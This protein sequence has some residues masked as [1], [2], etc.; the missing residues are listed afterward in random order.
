MGCTPCSL[1]V[2]VPVCV[3]THSFFLNKYASWSSMTYFDP[4]HSIRMSI[5]TTKSSSSSSHD[6]S[7]IFAAA[8]LPVSRCFACT[9]VGSSKEIWAFTALS[10][11]NKWQ[12]INV[13]NEAHLVHFPK[14]SVAKFSYQFPQLLWIFIF[15][16]VRVFPL[17]LLRRPPEDILQE[18]H[19]FVLLKTALPRQQGEKPVYS[20]NFLEFYA[21]WAVN[22][23]PPHEKKGQ[24]N[25]VSGLSYQYTR[26]GKPQ[27]LRFAV[28][29]KANLP[30]LLTTL[31]LNEVFLDWF[32]QL[33]LADDRC[34]SRKSQD[35]N[36]HAQLSHA[37]SRKNSSEIKFVPTFRAPWFAVVK[38]PERMIHSFVCTL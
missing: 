18:S 36:S 21:A 29:R 5:S 26:E 30:D 19:S 2:Y 24:P 23:L 13:H 31:H 34:R 11:P 27:Q 9:K 6:S 10:A 3:L 16:D 28:K 38:F 15:F 22:N 33:F 1:Q 12:A 37:R 35:Q 7:T 20:T 8:T 4:E 14:S 32:R 25:P 17:F